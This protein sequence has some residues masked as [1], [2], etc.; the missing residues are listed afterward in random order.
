MNLELDT[1]Q[2][3]LIAATAEVCE[4]FAQRWRQGR[5]ATDRSD[6]KTLADIGVFGVRHPE[7]HGAGL[8]PAEA[9]LVAVECGAAL[10]PTPL[11]IWAD[12]VGSAVPGALSGEVVVTGSLQAGRAISFGDTADV[13]VL[14]E[15]DGVYSVP[16]S[17]LS[18]LPVTSVDPT[19]PRAR[20]RGDGRRD[21]IAN[22]ATAKTWRWQARLLTAAHLAGVG[23]AAVRSGVAH[24]RQ[25]QQF[26]QPIGSFQAVKHLLADAYT[27]VEMAT[28]Q[29]LV[30]AVCW[31]DG[32]PAAADQA[33]AA[34]LVAGRAAVTAAETAIQVHGGMG[35]TTE[36]LP[37]LYYKRALELVDEY[38]GAELA[39][40][41][42]H[43][44]LTLDG[45]IE[46]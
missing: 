34:A 31:A 18:W 1:D 16:S 26:G 42:L 3:D 9:A 23:R 17:T 45:A 12:L 25:R 28:S 40:T 5:D 4:S 29:V 6:L 38:G 13:I 15:A 36:A 44:D 11:L 33:T 21:R 14:V 7:P 30:A 27:A 20:P 2:R 43:R 41:I 37:H 8:G 19:M 24:A 10:A 35:F 39:D 32:H 22:A 46:R